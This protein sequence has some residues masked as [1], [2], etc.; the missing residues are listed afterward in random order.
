MTTTYENK[1]HYSQTQTWFFETPGNLGNHSL[2]LPAVTLQT[3]YNQSDFISIYSQSQSSPASVVTLIKVLCVFSFAQLCLTLWTA[4]TVACQAPLS[5]EFSRPEY[6]CELP[7]P[8]PGE[9]PNL[10]IKLESLVSPALAGRFF[11]TR[12]LG[13][14]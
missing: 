3:S 9:R 1:P 6:W 7:F 11:T 10:G 14:P 2:S 12:T 13:K 4:W 5:T 8:T